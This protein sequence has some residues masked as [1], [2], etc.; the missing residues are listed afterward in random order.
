MY[1]DLFPSTY[2]HLANSDK[3]RYSRTRA[4]IPCSPLRTDIHRVSMRQSTH[5]REKPSCA[6]TLWLETCKRSLSVNNVCLE[7]SKLNPFTS[8]IFSQKLW[9][10]RSSFLPKLWSVKT[11]GID[12]ESRISNQGSTGGFS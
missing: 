1:P 4:T 3:H 9:H 2:F 6:D 8:K 11:D 10:P 12:K 7:Y 5:P